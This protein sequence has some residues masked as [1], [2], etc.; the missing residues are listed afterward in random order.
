MEPSLLPEICMKKF[1][2]RVLTSSF[3]TE[4]E[5]IIDFDKLGSTELL[6]SKHA[7]DKISVKP[8]KGKTTRQSRK[9]QVRNFI[10]FVQKTT[11]KFPLKR[12]C[13]VIIIH[14]TVTLFAVLLY[15]CLP[16]NI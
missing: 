15:F 8:R 2:L 14:L 5:M 4:S 12:I 10:H 6:K 9:K 11:A 13:V 7:K 3:S 16:L 1:L